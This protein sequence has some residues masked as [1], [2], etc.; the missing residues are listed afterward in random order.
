[1]IIAIFVFQLPDLGSSLLRPADIA[2]SVG[3][4]EKANRLLKWNAFVNFDSII[5]SLINAGQ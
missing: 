3:C 2:M 4:P 1:V 5:K